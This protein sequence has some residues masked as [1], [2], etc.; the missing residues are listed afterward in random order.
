MS[1]NE[2]RPNDLNDLKWPLRQHFHSREPSHWNFETSK[3]VIAKCNQLLFQRSHHLVGNLTVV[4]ILEFEDF[5]IGS[6]SGSEPEI[7]KVTEVISAGPSNIRSIDYSLSKWQ[8]YYLHDI[9]VYRLFKSCVKLMIQLTLSINLLIK[10]L[11]LDVWKITGCNHQLD[12]A[13]FVSLSWLHH[14]M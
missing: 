12:T 8:R 13:C 11:I 5:V 4:F 7:L 2:N 9:S 3:N 10:C 1:I 6:M 14:S